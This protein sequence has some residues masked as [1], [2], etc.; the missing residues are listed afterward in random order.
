MAEEPKAQDQ[1]KEQG[2]KA[3]QAKTQDI[4][5]T[6]TRE[7]PNTERLETK[8]REA[9]S[10]TASTEQKDKQEHSPTRLHTPRKKNT[11]P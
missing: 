2:R 11:T 6:K 10:A 8:D 4:P 7:K 5:A 1:N 3:V 9:Q